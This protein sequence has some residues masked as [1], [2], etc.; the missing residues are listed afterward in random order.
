M[1]K[2]AM[3]PML[4]VFPLSAFAQSYTPFGQCTQ[5][6]ES[7]VRKYLDVAVVDAAVAM[8]DS[9]SVTVESFKNMTRGTYDQKF[10]AVVAIRVTDPNL[11]RLQRAEGIRAVVKMSGDFYCDNLKIKSFKQTQVISPR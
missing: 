5:K 3:I 9:N 1:K 10:E 11:M 6:V 2:L 7:L 8:Y 4:I